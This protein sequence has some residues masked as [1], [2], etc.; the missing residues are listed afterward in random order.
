MFAYTANMMD[1]S[2]GG[3]AHATTQ[4][5]IMTGLLKYQTARDNIGVATTAMETRGGNGYIEDW[6]NSKLVRDAHIGVL[7]EGTS[8]INALDIITRAVAKEQAHMALAEGVAEKLE[9]V[10]AQVRPRY[11]AAMD[12]A[13][14]FA[15]R[16]A[17]QAESEHLCRKASTALYHATSAALMAWE[18]ATAEAA[19]K[20]TNRTALAQLVE[21]TKLSP[22][23][24]FADDDLGRAGALVDEALGFAG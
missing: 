24:P 20:P 22:Q 15:E 7:W 9:D 6:V 17:S 18:G 12:K 5:R 10:P 23:D 19:G 14:D 1:R 8:N 3:D 21:D 11:Q 16:V 2:M 13:V 4:L